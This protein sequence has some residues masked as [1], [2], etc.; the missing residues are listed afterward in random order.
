MYED[1]KQKYDPKSHEEYYLIVIHDMKQAPSPVTGKPL[2]QYQ[3][4]R[5]VKRLK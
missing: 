2:T 1:R 4:I 3:Y 5:K